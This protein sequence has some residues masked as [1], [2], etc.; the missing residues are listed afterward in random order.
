MKEKFQKQFQSAVQQYERCKG[1]CIESVESPEYKLIAAMLET[2][3]GFTAEQ[4][5]TLIMGKLFHYNDGEAK[6]RVGGITSFY[7]GSAVWTTYESILF[8]L[9][10]GWW[11]MGLD[12]ADVWLPSDA[13]IKSYRQPKN[14]DSPYAQEYT[15]N[16]HQTPNTAMVVACTEDETLKVPNWFYT[17]ILIKPDALF[18]FIEVFELS[19]FEFMGVEFSPEDAQFIGSGYSATDIKQLAW[20]L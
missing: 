17:C 14:S 2:V 4:I 19:N 5:N 3:F 11:P 20:I 8:F 12:K 1:N 16:Y 18:D 13:E 9:N 7:G 6:C 15:I 10:T